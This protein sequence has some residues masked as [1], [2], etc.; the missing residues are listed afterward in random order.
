MR[1]LFRL[2]SVVVSLVEIRPLTEAD[3]YQ[4]Y[5]AHLRACPVCAEL[6]R[7][8]CSDGAALHDGWKEI[9]ARQE[10]FS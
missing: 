4:A 3:A 8:D 5:V 9:E 2:G 6:G 7:A 10:A 1:V